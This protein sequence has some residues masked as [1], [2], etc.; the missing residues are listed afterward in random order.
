MVKRDYC[1]DTELIQLFVSLFLL[2]VDTI[3]WLV[4]KK[5]KK[6]EVMLTGKQFKIPTHPVGHWLCQ[7]YDLTETA[8]SV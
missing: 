5:K 6:E 1:S 8:S 4:R 7:G 3:N 2:I